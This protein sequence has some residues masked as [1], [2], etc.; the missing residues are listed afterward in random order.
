MRGRSDDRF[1]LDNSLGRHR[2]IGLESGGVRRSW[3]GGLMGGWVWVGVQVCWRV[4]TEKA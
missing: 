4:G 1:R 3:I 2:A